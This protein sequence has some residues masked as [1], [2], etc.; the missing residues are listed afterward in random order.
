MSQRDEQL[1]RRMLNVARL[2]SETYAHGFV[3]FGLFALAKDDDG[4]PC[5]GETHAVSL[6]ENLVEWGLLE[7][8]HGIALGGTRTETRHRR[9]KFTKKAFALWSQE[10]PPIAGVADDRVI[11]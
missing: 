10:I 7:E 9:F 1:R 6:I 4:L 8:A 5:H 11:Q 2:N 3:P